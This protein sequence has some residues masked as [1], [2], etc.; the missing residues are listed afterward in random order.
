MTNGL[1][2][3][4]AQVIVGRTSELEVAHV[5]E[6]GVLGVQRGVEVERLLG[7]VPVRAGLERDEDGKELIG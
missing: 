1:G 3:D 2:R 6:T 7:N 4:R 5:E